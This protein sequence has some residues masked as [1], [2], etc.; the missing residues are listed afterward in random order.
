MKI[1]FFFAWTRDKD[2]TSEYTKSVGGGFSLPA[3]FKW[4]KNK[5]TP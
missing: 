5:I 1:N 4:I 3:I 2:K